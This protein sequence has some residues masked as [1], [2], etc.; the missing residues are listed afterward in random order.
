LVANRDVL[1]DLVN[2]L[3]EKETLNKEEIEKVFKKV[4]KV[5]KR[6][7][8]TGSKQ[9]VPSD[10]PPVALKPAKLKVKTEEKPVKKASPKKP[11]DNE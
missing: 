8:W 6:A 10:I 7:A 1:D 9:R 4:K 11:A 5:R 2:E 3:L